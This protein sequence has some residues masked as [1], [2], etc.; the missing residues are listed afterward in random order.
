MSSIHEVELEA[1]Q[2]DL[3]LETDLAKHGQTSRHEER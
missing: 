3:G 1:D 2:L